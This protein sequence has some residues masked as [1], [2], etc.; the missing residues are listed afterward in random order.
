MTRRTSYTNIV[1]GL[2]LI[3]KTDLI[4]DQRKGTAR[5]YKKWREKIK[6]KERTAFNNLT[7]NEAKES[8]EVDQDQANGKMCNKILVTID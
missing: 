1:N 7:K 2:F 3:I 6:G 4:R 5:E 8:A